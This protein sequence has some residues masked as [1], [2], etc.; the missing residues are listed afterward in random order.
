MS[1]ADAAQDADDRPYTRV[2]SKGVVR[3][4]SAGR[5]QPSPPG[6]PELAAEPVAE[7]AVNVAGG[8]DQ[9]QEET[10]TL[11]DRTVVERDAE[12]GLAPSGGSSQWPA[13]PNAPNAWPP[14]GPVT[15]SVVADAR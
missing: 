3:P 9:D 6:P 15:P 10:E 8:L 7:L 1:A 12:S 13:A 4:A 2:S 14:S 11:S 5:V